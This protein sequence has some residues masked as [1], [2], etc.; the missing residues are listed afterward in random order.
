M[1]IL[2]LDPATKFGWAYGDPPT[3]ASG[4]WDLS[5]RRDE[6]G[7]MRLIRLRSKLHE[8]YNAGPIDLVVF[9]TVS[10]TGKHMQGASVQG[11]MLG[12]VKTWCHDHG[13]EY[14]G[15]NPQTIKKHALA[16]QPKGS[17]RDKEAMVKAACRRWPAVEI[18]DDNHADALWLLDLAQSEL[19]TNVQ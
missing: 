19:G 17:K 10:Y 9:E 5:I 11:E 1:R 8:V 12:V 13:V 3:G 7:G 2:A 15:Y 14:A 6:S 16:D 4:V 18:I